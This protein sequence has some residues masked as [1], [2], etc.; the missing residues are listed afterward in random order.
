MAVGG[1]LVESRVLQQGLRNREAEFRAL[2]ENAPVGIYRRDRDGNLLG[3]NRRL[4]TIF[5]YE[6]PEQLLADAGLL[7]RIESPAMEESIA[8]LG[9]GELM[10]G[11]RV[12]ASRVDGRDILLHVTASRSSDRDE[13]LGIVEDVT[14][15]SALED[16]LQRARRLD[17]VGTLASGIAHDFNNLLCGILGYASMLREDGTMDARGDKAAK[18]IED[19]AERGADLTRRLLGISRDAPDEIEAVDVEEVLQDCARI[20]GETF[21]RRITVSVN[22]EKGLPKVVGRR[23]DLH[24]CVLNLCI[25]ARDAMTD[26]GRLELAARRCE[27]TPLAE[28]SGAHDGPW[29]C[30]DV[31][32]NG[33]GMDEATRERL[34]EPFFTTKPRG[35]GTGLGLYM[36]FSTMSAHGGVID[37]ETEIGAG[38]TIRISLPALERRREPTPAPSSRPIRESGHPGEILLVEDEGAI[39]TLFAQIL[40]GAGHRVRSAP[41]GVAAVKTLMNDPPPDLVILDLVLPGLSG[42]DVYRALR[43]RYPDLPVILSSGN[44]DDALLDPELRD[45]VAAVLRK[46]YRPALLAETVDRV[47]SEQSQ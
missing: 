11:R 4:T 32:D 41:D 26:G 18:A 10:P 28:G 1:S 47:L 12:T 3:A 23:T 33:C 8:S 39:R 40:E 22:A 34:F 29:V 6:S 43:K 31:K 24:Q 7:Q 5:G 42:H 30:I 2:V 17:A 19:A 25:N 16:H 14:E 35:K 20:A 46:P 21:D 44:V 37:V 15:S 38:S 36:V 45:G 13:I 27:I 9:E